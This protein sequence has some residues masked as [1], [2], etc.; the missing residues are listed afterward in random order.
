MSH[1]AQDP[2]R[3]KLGCK[4]CEQEGRAGKSKSH[5]VNIYWQQRKAH[6]TRAAHNQPG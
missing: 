5:L 4:I 2:S 3:C 1:N 6:E